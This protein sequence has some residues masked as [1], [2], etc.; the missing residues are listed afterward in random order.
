ML[1]E[2]VV[3]DEGTS[4]VDC[5]EPDDV[6][7]GAVCCA[8]SVTEPGV[9]VVVAVGTRTTKSENRNKNKIRIYQ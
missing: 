6:L 7:G 3:E 8:A 9:T 5:E 1:V 4:D 2:V